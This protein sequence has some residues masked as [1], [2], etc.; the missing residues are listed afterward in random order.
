MKN[1][2]PGR[3]LDFLRRY[4]PFQDLSHTFLRKLIE[5][6]EVRYVKPDTHIFRM[7]ETASSQ[8]YMVRQGAVHLYREEKQERTLIDTC[9]EGDLFGFRPLLA[10]KTYILSAIATEES[11]LYII[12]ASVLEAHMSENPDL[13]IYM[14]RAI[15]ADTQRRYQPGTTLAGATVSREG[16]DGYLSEVQAV[17]PKRAPVT[18]QVDTAIRDAA[19]R[20]SEQQVSSIVMVNQE[21]HPMGI[22]TDK[23]LRRRVATGEVAIDQPVSA[24]M[25]APVRT[26]PKEITAAGLQIAMV[27]NR[28]HHLVLT[29][30]G[31]ADSTVTGILTEHDLLVA[32]GS[33]PAVLIRRIRRAENTDQLNAI[34]QRSEQLLHRYLQQEVS[35]AFISTVMT[36]IND[37]LIRRAVRLC[38]QGMRDDPPTAFCWLAL[39]SQGREEQ[40]L[41]T[42]QDNALIFADV[43]PDRLSAVRTWFLAFAKTVTDALHACGFAYCPADMMAS[44]PRWCLSLS[45]W[46]QQFS[47]WLEEPDPQAVMHSTIFFDYR[48][49]YGDDKLA[50]ELTRHIFEDL[51]ARGQ[52]L[53]FLAKNALQNPP[54]LTFFRS[55]VVE[56]SGEHK[57]AFDIKARAMMPLADAARVLILGSRLGKINN[58][59][60]RF[61]ELARLEP[62]NSDL[63]EQA[64]EA[65]EILMRYRALRGLEEG[66]SG[67]YIRP[68][69]L[70]KIERLNLRHAFSPIRKL[71]NL[72]MTRYKLAYLM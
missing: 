27:K 55:F 71:Q 17:S 69:A 22:L 20:M 42:D 5:D 62:Q 49:V 13:A 35:I 23:D 8:L 64:A 60:R 54:P 59:F 65:Y 45:E 14:A 31:T 7:G 19:L 40:L 68:D 12:P 32:Q 30:D 43:A 38:M 21:G 37:A 36:Q 16:A 24:I 29:E 57:D 18:C 33:N 48:P 44:N 3:I 41:R 1:A 46:Q 52:F 2:I 47:A 50:E 70:S 26:A 15:A 34:R 39:G 53:T 9:D 28:I 67:R 58:T 10:E 63:F 51:N 6:I 11:L 56:K 72:L 66:D 25:S 61:A 4:P